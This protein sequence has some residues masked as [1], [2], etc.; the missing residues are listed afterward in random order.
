[1]F[2]RNE[3]LAVFASTKNAIQR[4]WTVLYGTAPKDKN[5]EDIDEGI[6][7]YLDKTV[8]REKF[9][10]DNYG[11]FTTTYSKSY[12]Y[13]GK[14]NWMDK[15]AWGDDD[16]LDEPKVTVSSYNGAKIC[17]H[18]CL[19]KN[20][21]VCNPDDKDG[22][23]LPVKKYNQNNDWINAKQCELCDKWF[24]EDD[25][26]EVT[27]LFDTSEGVRT[28][29]WLMCDDCTDELSEVISDCEIARPATT[30]HRASLDEIPHFTF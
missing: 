7:L 8:S 4:A 18:S 28:E 21:E 5:I 23:F 17:R 29:K 11:Y 14:V 22:S 6:T 26:T 2:Y 30:I 25:L 13:G 12:S 16:I 9:K 27:D 19:E 3:D 10:P 20:C 15:Q 24:G 1:M